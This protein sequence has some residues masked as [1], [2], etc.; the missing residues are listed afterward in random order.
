[1]SAINPSG[2]CQCGCGK[3]APIARGMI[4]RLGHV[5]GHPVKFI[6]GHNMRGRSGRRG[7]FKYPTVGSVDK[8]SE[9]A[10]FHNMIKRC[11]RKTNREYPNYGG[12]GIKVIGKMR[13][14]EGFL[15]VMG[16]KPESGFSIGRINNDGN[17]EE[18]NVRWESSQQQARNR[19]NNRLTADKVDALRVD[20]QDGTSFAELACKWGISERY[21]RR[22]VARECWR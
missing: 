13:T 22:V 7:R 12:R 15:E 4:T 14:F 21:A 9:F 11:E 8:S 6:H 17:Y 20:R 5:K 16:T 18:G 19:R 3:P 2:L 1:M 10:A